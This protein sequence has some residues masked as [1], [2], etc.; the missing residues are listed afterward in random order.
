MG[1]LVAAL[2]ADPE[3]RRLLQEDPGLS[4][5]AAAVA[6]DTTAVAR[7]A[8]MAAAEVRLLQ[9]VRLLLRDPAVQGVVRAD[10]ELRRLWQNDALRR[11]IEGP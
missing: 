10:P 6:A 11:L 4:S 7:A 5:A 3:V 1:A 9:V 8:A 2:L